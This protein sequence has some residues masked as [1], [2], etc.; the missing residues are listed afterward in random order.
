MLRRWAQPLDLSGHQTS[1]HV[2]EAS[3]VAQALV[4][5]AKGNHVSMIVMGSATHGLQMQRFVATI[6]IKVAME[7]PCTVVLVK[8][9]VPFDQLAATPS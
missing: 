7:A 4:Q 3:D 5:Y 9:H 1:Y 8:Q 2:L 6:P